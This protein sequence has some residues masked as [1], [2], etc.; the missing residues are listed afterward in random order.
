MAK[1]VYRYK[2]KNDY[3]Y[4]HPVFDGIE[5]E[6]AWCRIHNGELTVKKGYATDGCSP[7]WQ[8]LGLIT[9]GTPDGALH[10]GLPWTYWASLVHDVLCQFADQI[11]ICR[12]DATRVFKD[13]LI[14][15]EWPLTPVYVGFVHV[16]G[17]R[18]FRGRDVR[19]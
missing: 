14:R 3:T 10:F 19:A 11:A 8:P 2:L 15:D 17:P 1:K 4:R 16:F 6:N 13:I 7:K 9:I 5:F 12:N 18:N